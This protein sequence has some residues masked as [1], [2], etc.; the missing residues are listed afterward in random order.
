MHCAEHVLVPVCAMLTKQDDKA[1]TCS[2]AACEQKASQPLQGPPASTHAT[3][4]QHTHKCACLHTH[5]VLDLDTRQHGARNCQHTTAQQ[6][7]PASRLA[8]DAAPARCKARYVQQA[9]QCSRQC[10]H[11]TKGSWRRTAAHP[12]V[13]SA[14][15]H[16][17]THCLR[18][19]CPQQGSNKGT[20]AY[21][22]H[23]YMKRC[24]CLYNTRDC[25]GNCSACHSVRT[26]QCVWYTRICACCAT[27]RRSTDMARIIPITVHS[28]ALTAARISQT[29]ECSKPSPA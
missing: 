12:N 4:T 8:A 26:P 16:S 13:R 23:K 22:T 20:L 24:G 1:D 11:A 9:P 29:T 27:A 21:H 18:P 17:D 7:L 10:A 15:K 14:R 2:C 3:H 19:S 5:A 25:K 6:T 28:F